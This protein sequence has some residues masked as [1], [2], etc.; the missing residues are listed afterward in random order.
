MK[1]SKRALET[2][3]L[4]QKHARD[5]GH[6]SG[7]N[8]WKDYTGTDFYSG[9]YQNETGSD[10][11]G[12]TPYVI[13]E[14]NTDHYPLMS[15]QVPWDITGP[16]MWVPDGKCDIRDVALIALLFGSQKGDGRYD[17]RADTTGPTYLVPDG[18]V[19]IRDMA[20]IAIHYGEVYQ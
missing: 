10:G 16:V 14:N 9:P 1:T 13:D 5:D 2:N 7:C 17:A 3:E 18:K 12:D 8:Y 11:I 19:D 4:Y 15:P 20:L 6:P